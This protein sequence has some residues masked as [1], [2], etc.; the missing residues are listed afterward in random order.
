M[1]CGNQYD[2]PMSSDAL[3]A[4][5]NASILEITTLIITLYNRLKTFMAE[6]TEQ[7]RTLAHAKSIAAVRSI[8]TN[9]K[10][11][12]TQMAAALAEFYGLLNRIMQLPINWTIE[13]VAR[14]TGLTDEEAGRA[15]HEQVDEFCRWGREIEGMYLQDDCADLVTTVD[16]RVEQRIA[17]IAWQ[18]ETDR[19]RQLAGGEGD[20]AGGAR[21]GGVS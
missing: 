8:E 18:A 17:V 11:R 4:W 7:I 15:T 5:A 1:S 21:D 3:A 12:I 19:L 9:L 10:Q 13:L 20:G 16:S 2:G 6:H 14:G